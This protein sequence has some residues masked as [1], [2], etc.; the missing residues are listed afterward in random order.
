MNSDHIKGMGNKVKGEIKDAVGKATNSPET[1]V[2]G[3]L[4]KAKGEA[5]Q[6]KGDIRDQ[7]SR[8]ADK[9]LDKTDDAIDGDKQR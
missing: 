4:D 3:Q 7:A 9:V 6:A 5:Q 8:T 1:R 2:S